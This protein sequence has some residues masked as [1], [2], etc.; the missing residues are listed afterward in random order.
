[1]SAIKGFS[2]ELFTADGHTFPIFRKGGGYGVILL[3]ELPGLT[4]ETVEFAE[5][6]VDRGFHVVMPLLFGSPLQPVVRG[7]LQAP[8][9]CIRR[10]FNTLATGKSS[11]ITLPLR[12][13]CRK[14]HAECGGPGVGAIGMCYTGGFVLAMMLEASLLAPVAAQP[15]LPLCQP[16]GLDVEP[17]AL[18]FAS[19]RRDTMSLLGLRFEDDA[20]CPA[21]RFNRLEASL[22]P[23]PASPVPRF[24]SVTVPGKAHSTLTLDYPAALKGGVDTREVVLQHLRKQL[25]G[26]SQ[27]GYSTQPT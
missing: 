6:L 11:T 13:L 3:H 10:E 1:M 12:T 5:W 24:H 4:S 26:S 19:A 18:S 14:I 9:I 8:F 27:P 25:L 21:S 2:E 16:E 22:Q 15:S 20:L 7:L 23:A 17:E